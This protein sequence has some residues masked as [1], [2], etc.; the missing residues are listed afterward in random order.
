M[1][2]TLVEREKAIPPQQPETK[3]NKLKAP[4]L[5]LFCY[6]INESGMNK[7]EENES[8][9]NYCKRICKQFKLTYSDRI[10]QNFNG[11]DVKKPKRF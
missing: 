4:V 7:K 11:S 6:L 2:E 9:E 8:V 5:A 10:R 1:F 3:T